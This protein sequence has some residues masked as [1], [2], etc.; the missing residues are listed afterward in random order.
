MIITIALMISL[1]IP[2]ITTIMMRIPSA[3]TVAGSLEPSSG[4]RYP[5]SSL[6]KDSDPSQ[7]P[8]KLCGCS[9]DPTINRVR[10][11]SRGKG[12]IRVRITKGLTLGVFGL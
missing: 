4:L 11:S 10:V 1:M 9:Y 8:Q 6:L 2:I 12:R 7:Y 3:R 5:L